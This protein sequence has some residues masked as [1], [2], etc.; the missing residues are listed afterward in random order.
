MLVAGIVVEA[1]APAAP[2][3]KPPIAV[4]MRREEEV[5]VQVLLDLGLP[6]DQQ[7][8][9]PEELVQVQEEPVQMDQTMLPELV[10]VQEAQYP[11]DLTVVLQVQELV[12]G[13][14]LAVVVPV[15]AVAKPCL[16]TD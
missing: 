4:V 16:R 14:L 11:I 3:V 10:Q 1:V 6:M 9:E 2:K 8:L 15:A 13:V 12:G 7:E 5:V